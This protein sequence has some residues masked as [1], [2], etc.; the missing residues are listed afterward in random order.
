MVLDME[1]EFYKIAK[2]ITG[3]PK[4]FHKLFAISPKGR[5][6]MMGADGGVLVSNGMLGILLRSNPERA[7]R[8]GKR[9]ARDSFGELVKEFDEEVE[10]L[11]PQKKFELAIGMARATGWGEIEVVSFET[12]RME[13]TLKV[14]RTIEGGFKED[15]GYML[16]AGYLAGLASICFSSDMDCST[17][18]DGSGM[19]V[20]RLHRGK[21]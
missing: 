14:A 2:T 6:A 12:K 18:Q 19:T 15:S 1:S 7:Y 5:I 13:A 20:F 17:E 16:T 10:N 21:G 4:N 8:C 9:S 11:P 3:N